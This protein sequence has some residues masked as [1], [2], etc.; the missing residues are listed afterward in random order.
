[1]PKKI[2]LALITT[3]TAFSIYKVAYAADF[4]LT[5]IGAMSTGG[6]SY[7]EWWYTGNNPTFVGT[8]DAD[9]T[10][11]YDVDGSTGSVT[12]DSSGNWSYNAGLDGGDH[13]VAFSS[14]GSTVSF[15]IHLGQSLPS[16]FG[17]TTQSTT[18]VPDT[19]SYQALAASISVSAIVAGLYLWSRAPKNKK[20]TFEQEITDYVDK[21]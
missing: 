12:A 10:V 17:G 5:Q 14:G 2:V 8:S 11:Q 4:A 15:T 6:A 21:S 1:M 20:A 7:S 19:G 16:D 18:S 3:L 13:S 9:A